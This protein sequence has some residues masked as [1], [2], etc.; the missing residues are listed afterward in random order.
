MSKA[1]EAFHAAHV[2]SFDLSV[3]FSD[4]T[5]RL[6]EEFAGTSVYKYYGE[7]R[8]GF[9]KLPQLRFTQKSGL[10]DP[11]ELTRR[12]EQFGSPPTRELLTNYVRDP[13]MAM[14]RSPDLIL[15]LF[16]ERLTEMGVPFDRNFMAARLK[17]PEGQLFMAEQAQQ[18]E[19]MIALVMR[20]MLDQMSD[21]SDALVDDL[22]QK[23]G[24]FSVSSSGLSQP[25]WGLYASSGAGFVVKFH[26]RHDFFLGK[27]DGAPASMLRKVHY[28][29]QRIA[30]FWNNPYYLFGVKETE[31]AF[32][33]ELRMIK[34]LKD[35][36]NVGISNGVPVFVL[37][38]VPG[39]IDSVIF[40]Y[41]YDKTLMSEDMA[42]ISRMDPSVKFEGA[43][44]D[45]SSSQL[46][47]QPL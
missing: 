34:E 23:M 15:E 24:I 47:V 19:V 32:E 21:N 11:F 10:N 1:L 28:T 14:M 5:K 13:V 43:A 36:K 2:N 7:A 27:R 35:C 40:G 4:E 31:W 6:E 3:L 20:T 17:S 30:D 39:M 22:V 25:M 38:V 8:R 12:W 33:K 46:T 18:T 16:C 45:L 26:A 42:D 37:D 41:N 44:V 9:F 29:D